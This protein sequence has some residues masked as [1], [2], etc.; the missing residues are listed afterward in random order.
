M[1]IGKNANYKLKDKFDRTPLHIAVENGCTNVVRILVDKEANLN[2]KDSYG[3]TPLDYANKKF[4]P[5]LEDMIRKKEVFQ[6]NV[7]LDR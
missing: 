1:L 6:E 2:L 4:K 3:K 5:V 7:N